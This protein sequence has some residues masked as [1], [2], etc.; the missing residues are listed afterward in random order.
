MG[1]GSDHWCPATGQGAMGTNK[2]AL[3]S[4]CAACSKEPALGADRDLQRSLPTP[5]VLSFCDLCSW[6]P[7]HYEHVSVKPYNTVLTSVSN[8]AFS[9][10]SAA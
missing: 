1:P 8:S 4:S 3:M 9:F 6:S 5:T 2:P 10:S 7:S